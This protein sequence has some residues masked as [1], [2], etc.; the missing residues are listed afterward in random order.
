MSVIFTISPYI[1]I[2]A[3]ILSQ[4]D[5]WQLYIPSM[6]LGLI[7]MA[8]AVIIGEKKTDQKLYF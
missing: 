2:K 3:N 8:P 1:L 4:E 5:I 7:A 6:L